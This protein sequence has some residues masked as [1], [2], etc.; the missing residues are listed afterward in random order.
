VVVEQV[1]QIILPHQVEEEEQVV[2]ENLKV[3]LIHIL[4]VL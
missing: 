4:Q 2:I 1:A 3:L